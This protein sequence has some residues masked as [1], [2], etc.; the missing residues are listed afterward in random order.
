MDRNSITGLILI[1]LILLGFYFFNRPNAEQIAA[2]NQQRD[3]LQRVELQRQQDEIARAAIAA[4]ESAQI[5]IS[6]SALNDSSASFGWP[7][8]FSAISLHSQIA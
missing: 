8:F 1:T 3:S 6:D 4:A 5:A 2:L 7:E